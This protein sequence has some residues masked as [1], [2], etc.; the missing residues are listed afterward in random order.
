[1]R[2]WS[3]AQPGDLTVKV[4]DQ[5]VRLS[6]VNET[7][8]EG[9]KLTLIARP[10]MLQVGDQGELAG[11]VRRASYLGNMFDYDVEVGGQLLTVVDTDPRHTVIYPEGATVRVSL[12]A[13]CIHVLPG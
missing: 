10:E 13:D 8:P 12:L 4:F 9:A 5:T 7:L 3:T 1:M 11:I 6:T 2:R